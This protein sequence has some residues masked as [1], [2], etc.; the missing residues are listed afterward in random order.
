M[1]AEGERIGGDRAAGIGMAAAAAGT[2]LAMAHHPSG[3]HADGLGGLVHGAMILFLAVLA[4]GFLH[5]ARRRGLARPAMLAGLVAY[6]V[7]MFAHVGA[8]TINGFVVPA[9]AARGHG[10]VGHDI[11]LL[12]WEANQALARLG[13]YATGA[14]FMLWGADL[15]RGPGG[16]T[17]LLG[18]LGLI[19]G[20]VPAGLLAFGWIGMNLAGAFAVYAAH[21]AWSA[22]VGVQLI[23]GRL[24]G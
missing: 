24:A 18:A 21:A 20:A 4:W 15:L 22:L 23:R 14:G 6:G 8:A 10:A 2:I 9:L 19:A 12:A 1:K 16:E 11:F 3:A 5:F 17:R 13:V 7:S